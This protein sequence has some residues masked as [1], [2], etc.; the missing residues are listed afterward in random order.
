VFW[1]LSD[2][3]LALFLATVALFYLPLRGPVCSILNKDRHLR[4]VPP[5]P[6]IASRWIDRFHV[7]RT[8]GAR[9]MA[10]ARINTC[11]S[12]LITTRRSEIEP[13]LSD[14]QAART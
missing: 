4:A 12:N 7:S 9:N 11:V 14:V 13:E 2:P 10:G 5:S 6:G 3:V 8:D 1:F